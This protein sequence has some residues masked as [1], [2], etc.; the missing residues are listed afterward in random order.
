MEGLATKAEIDPSSDLSLDG[1]GD[2]YFI[3]EYNTVQKDD[4]RIRKVGTNGIITTIAGNGTPGFSGDG[5]QAIAAEIDPNSNISPLLDSNGNLYFSDGNTRIRKV[6]THGIITT[7]AGDGTRGF[8][9]DG[10]PVTSAEIDPDDL[11]LDSSGDIYFT[12]GGFYPYG[13]SDARI[14]KVGTDGIINTVAGDGYQGLNGDG[15]PATRAEIYGDIA[16]LDGS[17]AIYFVNWDPSR[18]SESV[19]I[20]RVANG[21]ITTFAGN[22]TEGVSGDEGLASTT[23]IDD[24]GG[25]AVDSNGNLY[26]ADYNNYLIWKVDT[27]GAISPVAGDGE[28]G[29]YGVERCS[30]SGPAIETPISSPLGLAVDHSENLFFANGSCS[31]SRVDI[32]GVLTAFAG[33]A[34]TCGYG[35]DGGPATSALLEF[36]VAA[37]AVDLTGNLYIGDT[38]SFRIRQVDANGVITTVAGNGAAGYSG[39]GEL[40]TNA[41][42]GHPGGIAADIA[43][44]LYI[45][46]GDNFRV[47]KVDNRGIITTVAGNGTTGFSGDGGPATNAQISDVT[48][49]AIDKAGNLYIGDFFNNSKG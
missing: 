45:A 48:G 47:R 39:D 21:T 29:C 32:Y 1:S 27:L 37:V 23:E 6:D 35:G 42:I 4:I 46:D 5:G 3:N 33:S 38:N 2:L 43:G 36:G 7:V 19:W 24:P 13:Q 22:G 26:V 8:G 25:I 17:G 30:I 41:E 31:V 9:G 18:A 28:V 12:D 14:R 11:W 44:N 49:L 16:A 40:A 10:G 20:R 34:D 15:G